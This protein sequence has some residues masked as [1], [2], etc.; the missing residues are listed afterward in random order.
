MTRVRDVFAGAQTQDHGQERL[1]KRP[2]I[3]EML[4]VAYRVIDGVDSV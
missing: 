1:D 4:A 3:E 2:D